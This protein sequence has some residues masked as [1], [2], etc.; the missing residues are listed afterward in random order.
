MVTIDGI[1]GRK[2]L[3]CSTDADCPEG[4]E[5]VDSIC[6]PVSDDGNSS[7]SEQFLKV[8]LSPRSTRPG[9]LAR[10]TRPGKS[11]SSKTCRPRRRVIKRLG[12]SA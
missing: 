10:T 7:D 4:Y 6:L 9:R 12:A 3:G 8:G 1:E 11:D 2:P 5:C